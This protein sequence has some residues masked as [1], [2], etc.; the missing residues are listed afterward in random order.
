MGIKM[1][2]KAWNPEFET[3]SLW[4]MSNTREC[5]WDLSPGIPNLKDCDWKLSPILGN[6]NGT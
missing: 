2:L 1:G 4:L 6:G 3:L 5:E